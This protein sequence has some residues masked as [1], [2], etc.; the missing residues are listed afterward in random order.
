[1]AGICQQKTK[2]PADMFG[3]GE[4]EDANKGTQE[5]CDKVKEE[6]QRQ[7][8]GDN[9]E[10]KAVKYRQLQGIL[11][12]EHFLIK[13]QVGGTSYIHLYVIQIV[14]PN[15]SPTLRGMQQN[16]TKDDALEPFPKPP[17]TAVKAS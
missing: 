10:Y 1:M 5:L 16:R 9:A 4:T 6:V 13:V 7:T 8:R 3:W 17:A 15:A 14:A 2:P 11:G 12:A